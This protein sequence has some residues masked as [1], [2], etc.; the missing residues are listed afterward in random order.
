M[1]TGFGGKGK[2]GKYN[3]L[4][5]ASYKGRS[6]ESKTSGKLFWKRIKII[7]QFI[8]VVLVSI[9]CVGLH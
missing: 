8:R 2:D 4:N 9:F 5:L 7:V 3:T 6:V 1:S